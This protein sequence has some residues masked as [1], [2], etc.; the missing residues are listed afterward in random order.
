MSK[1]NKK[2]KAILI[3]IYQLL[4]K[5][6]SIHVKCIIL[7]K[8]YVIFFVRRMYVRLLKIDF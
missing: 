6:M 1:I 3:F 7:A 5:N 2:S 8:I 4:V